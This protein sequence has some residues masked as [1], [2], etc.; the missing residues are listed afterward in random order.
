MTLRE[1]CAAARTEPE[2]RT[3]AGSLC[4]YVGVDSPHRDALHHLEDAVVVALTRW[5]VYVREFTPGTYPPGETS[6]GTAVNG[7]GMIL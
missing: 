7:W 6:G 2:L 4:L 5:T 1:W 3:E